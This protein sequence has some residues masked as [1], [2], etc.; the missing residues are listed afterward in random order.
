MPL[1]WSRVDQKLIHG[2]VSVAWVPYLR[3]DT[4]VVADS[5]TAD[6]NWSQ[7]VMMMGLPPEVA[8]VLFTAP[9]A[10]AGLLAG[11]ELAGRKVLAIFK[12]LRG[13]RAAIQAGLRLSHLN[14]GN[15]AFQPQTQEIKLGHTFYAG[16][17]D[18]DLL[19]ELSESGLEVILQ[20]VPSGKATRWRPAK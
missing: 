15:Q 3:A 13:V 7:K 8:T 11:P 9:E 5:D 2:Q 12:D 14:L 16:R 1:I 20:E 18:I 19:R 4:I 17:P 6:D 10:L